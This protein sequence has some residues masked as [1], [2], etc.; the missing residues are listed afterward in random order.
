MSRI[1]EIYKITN[2]VNQKCYIGQALCSPNDPKRGGSYKR[3]NDHI[4]Y[5]LKGRDDC[6][7]LC[8]AI[9]KYGKEVFIYEVLLSCNQEF[10]DD[11][12]TKFVELYDSCNKGY[13]ILPGGQY[14]KNA[15][16]K[17]LS[18][19]L[20][21]NIRE[22]YE[23]NPTLNQKLSNIL[24]D[25]WSN[26]E[27]RQKTL[28]KIMTQENIEAMHRG[29]TIKELPS[30]IFK[31]YDGEVHI[32]YR[33]SIKTNGKY[34]T[35][36]FKARAYTLEQKLEMAINAL[37]E[38][39]QTYC[40]EIKKHVSYDLPRGISYVKRNNEIVGYLVNKTLYGKT[41]SKKFSS[42][43]MSMEEKYKLALSQLEEFN[44]IILNTQ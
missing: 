29:K 9:R 42:V 35:K 28:E 4:S 20:S 7:K 18:E 34:H 6:P 25:R 24:D 21:N 13:N 10:L 17:E 14:R 27:Y 5:A 40:T 37:T 3:F 44:K 41:L 30:G 11:Y 2:I 15:D 23:S 16:S 31:I 8:K 38:L 32:G 39:K 12:E 1:G 26:D 33:A 43:K 36:T 19:M 22:A